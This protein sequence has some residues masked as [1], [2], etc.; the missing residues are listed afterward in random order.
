MQWRQHRPAPTPAALATSAPGSAA[1]LVGTAVEQMTN[2]HAKFRKFYHRA[3]L[4]LWEA[5]ADGLRL[6]GLMASK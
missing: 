2:L 3:E 5:D 4:T 1:D 6:M